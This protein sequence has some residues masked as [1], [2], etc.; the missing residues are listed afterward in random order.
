MGDSTTGGQWHPSACILCSVNCG[1]EI[2]V[3]DG[4][5]TRIRGDEPQRTVEGRLVKFAD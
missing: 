1:I 2:E 3:Q 5:F 4:R